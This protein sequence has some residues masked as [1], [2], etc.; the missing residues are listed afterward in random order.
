MMRSALLLLFPLVCAPLARAQDFTPPEPYGGK[1]AVNWLLEQEQH[2]PAEALAVG[3]SGEVGVSFKILPDGSVR[4]LRVT[5]PLEPACDAE[6]LRL[7]KMIRWRPASTNGTAFEKD[8]SLDI[9]FNAKKYTKLHAKKAPCPPQVTPLPADV[10]NT[11]YADNEVDTLAAPIIPGGL[12]Q[13]PNYLAR[14]LKYPPEAYRLDIQGKVTLDFVVETSGAVS[15]LRTLNFLGGGCDAEAMRLVRTLCW[16]PAVK[17]GRS[18]RSI[19]KLDI[20]FRLDPS[21][22]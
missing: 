20:R 10:S 1:D 22:H 6:A 16:K 17:D 19:M 7:A 3:L 12:R 11:L 8:H 15:N 18:V 9:P 2:F 14:N 21:Q 13:L 5:L 4:N